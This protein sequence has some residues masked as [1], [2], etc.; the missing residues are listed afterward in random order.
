MHVCKLVG[1]LLRALER[2]HHEVLISNE[3]KS[4]LQKY[5]EKSNK[6]S[7]HL[8]KTVIFLTIWTVNKT[9]LFLHV[10]LQLIKI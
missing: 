5:G 4:A 7:F 8:L 10:F 2:G 6:Y 1:F 3:S 9:Q